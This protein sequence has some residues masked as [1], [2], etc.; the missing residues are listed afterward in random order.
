MQTTVSA[1]HGLDIMGNKILKTVF[2]ANGMTVS[3]EE[4]IISNYFMVCTTKI[5]AE[6]MRW[7]EHG[8]RIERWKR[9]LYDMFNRQLSK[10]TDCF[11]RQGKVVRIVLNFMLMK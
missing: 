11:G 6:T 3:R 7:V 2:Q 8:A 5:K 10:E 1:G 9:S 4:K